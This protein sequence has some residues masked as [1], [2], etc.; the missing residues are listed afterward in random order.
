[1]HTP[2]LTVNGLPHTFFRDGDYLWIA[3][4]GVVSWTAAEGIITSPFVIDQGSLLQ[5]V[6]TLEPQSG[7]KAI[8]GFTVSQ[9]GNYKISLVVDAPNEGSNSIY[10]DIDSEPG[11]ERLWHIETTKGFEE[12]IASGPDD[13]PKIIMLDKGEHELIIRGREKNTRLR[14]ISLIPVRSGIINLPNIRN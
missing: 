11:L 5:K 2:Q 6:D 4:L 3:P 12:R 1:M 8:Y 10:W 9:A 14:E 13:K 7:G